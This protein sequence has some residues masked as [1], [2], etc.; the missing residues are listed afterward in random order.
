M[1]RLTHSALVLV[2]CV[3]VASTGCS[4]AFSPTLVPHGTLVVTVLD[5]TT[6]V[7]VL[8]PGV[9]VDLEWGVNPTLS[10]T[11]TTTAAGTVRLDWPTGDLQVRVALPQGFELAPGQGNPVSVTISK[12]QQSDVSFRLR[13]AGGV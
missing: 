9:R 1:F 2:C 13:R 8:M 12:E 10:Q 6:G 7:G 4:S 5:H 3:A 11:T